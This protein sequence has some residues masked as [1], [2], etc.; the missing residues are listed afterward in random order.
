MRATVVCKNL[1]DRFGDRLGDELA[2]LQSAIDQLNFA[3]A[4]ELGEALA[5]RLKKSA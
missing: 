4:R 1:T 5:Q 2:N 3:A